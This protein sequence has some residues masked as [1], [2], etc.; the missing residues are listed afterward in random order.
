MFSEDMINSFPS[1]AVRHGMA[2]VPSLQEVRDMLSLIAGIGL[3]VA[4]A[5]FLR[6]LRFVVMSCW[7]I[8]CNCLVVY[9]RVKLFHRI[10]RMHFWYLYLS[11]VI[12][13][14]VTIGEESVCW[15]MV[16]KV[17]AKVIQQHLQAV[18]EEVVADSQCDLVWF[19]V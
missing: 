15:I 2:C 9:G 14:C 7:C 3:V 16:G 1:Y 11:R 10:G 19:S 5:S 12:C 8:W 13:P 6:W 18:V 17:F 4:V